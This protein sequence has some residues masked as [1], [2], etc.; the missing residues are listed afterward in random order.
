MNICSKLNRDLKFTQL[1]AYSSQT[2]GS[3]LQLA[4]EVAVQ[5]TQLVLAPLPGEC[6]WCHSLILQE[7]G[8]SRAVFLHDTSG[9]SVNVLPI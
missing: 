5:P 3:F 9:V 6:L 7:P 4:G 2:P 8:S 1:R